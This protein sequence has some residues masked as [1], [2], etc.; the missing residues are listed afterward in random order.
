MAN[1]GAWPY[2]AGRVAVVIDGQSHGAG[3][4]NQHK[5]KPP[6][7]PAV[8]E[9][10]RK[11]IGIVGVELLAFVV[12][13]VVVSV[14][15]FRLATDFEKHAW[16]EFHPV[17]ELRFVL[18]EED[19]VCWCVKESRGVGELEDEE[20]ELVFMK[21]FGACRCMWSLCFMRNDHFRKTRANDSG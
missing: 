12:R 19:E 14:R 20:G 13:G 11:N 21:N 8:D 7:L 16:V 15:T 18:R 2:I 1:L 4:L 5:L 3:K 6:C 10:A 9:G 17:D